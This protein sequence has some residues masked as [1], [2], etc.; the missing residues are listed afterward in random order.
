MNKHK[1]KP[2]F[3]ICCNGEIAEPKYFKEYKDFL[4]S[5]T[6]VVEYKKFKQLAPWKLIKKAIY[7]KEILEKKGKFCKKDNDQCWCVFDVD[8][9]WNQN[10]KK[11]KIAVQLAKNNNIHL[12]WSNECFELWYL[13]HFQTLNTK[14]PRS[15]YHT[16]LKKHFKKAKLKP[17]IKNCSVFS[18]IENK[19]VTAIKNAKQIYKNNDVQKNPSTS[20]FK[21]VEEINKYLS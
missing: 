9:F 16:K 8:E 12:A 10:S 19:Q 7:K 21:L 13:L 15:D 2:K 11:F 6:I 4:K 20:I 5:R 18:K 17:Y 1:I 14:I 3:Y